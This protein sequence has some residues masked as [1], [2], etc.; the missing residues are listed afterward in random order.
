MSRSG[1]TS[2][3]H[4]EYTDYS[5]STSIERLA[6]DVETHLR[7]WHLVGTDRHVSFG[8]EH[9]ENASTLRSQYSFLSR[10][11]SSND[12]AA[13]ATAAVAAAAGSSTNNV[14]NNNNNN[15][16][17]NDTS[18]N[19]N[20]T[21]SFSADRARR[22][23][24]GDKYSGSDNDDNYQSSVPLIR[25]EK[26]EWTVTLAD[27]A[28]KESVSLV[29]SLWDGPS[30]PH[31]SS[32]ASS[33]SALPQS[34][35]R[36]PLHRMP[37]DPFA[38]FSSLLGIGQHITLSLAPS[39]TAANDGKDSDTNPSSEVEWAIARSL[40]GRHDERMLA[41]WIVTSSLSS[42][43]Q[44]S[45]QS[46][47]S[48]VSCRIPAFGLWG[49]YHPDR[50]EKRAW[51]LRTKEMYPSWLTPS[52]MVP[53]KRRSSLFHNS[54]ADQHC[55]QAYL[56]P[57]LSSNL[58]GGATFWVSVLPSR[59]TTN[60]LTVWGQLLLQHCD[61][62]NVLLCGAKHMYTWNKAAVA[63]SKQTSRVGLFSTTR[64]T[65]NLDLVDAWRIN[66]FASISGT[67]SE[68]IGGTPSNG[69]APDESD[70]EDVIASYQLE[71]CRYAVSLL[72]MASGAHTGEPMWGPPEDP[73]RVVHVTITWNGKKPSSSS[74]LPESNDAA[75]SSPSLSECSLLSM[76]LRIRS[77]KAMSKRDWM[78]MEDSV[79]RTILDPLSP[80][81]FI[82]QAQ[83][84]REI[85]MTPLAASQRC[86]LACM[87]RTATLPHNIMLPELIDTGLLHSWGST[88]TEIAAM[89]LVD[90]ARVSTLTTQLVQAMDWTTIA[91]EMMEG[92]ESTY[93]VGR[94]MN[95]LNC[96]GFPSPPA[97]LF[98]PDGVRESP[99]DCLPKSAP[100]G[101]LLSLLF[102]QMSKLR[103]PSAMAQ[104]WLTFVADVRER[105]DNRETLPNMMYIP[106]LD[107][108]PDE[109]SRMRSS[110]TISLKAD[111]SAF[112]NS[113]EP[114]PDQ[115]YCLIGQKL[116]IFN[117]GVELAI[118]HEIREA[119]RFE[120]VLH[121]TEPTSLNRSPSGGA[122]D[123]NDG[124]SVA[125]TE[126]M[127]N[128][129]SSRDV[130]N[131]EMTDSP[132]DHLAKHN[133]DD[134][135]RTPTIRDTHMP[136]GPHPHNDV[137]QQPRLV[138]SY[139]IDDVAEQAHSQSSTS[140]KVEFHDARSLLS[141]SFGPTD[142][143]D[144]EVEVD[145]MVATRDPL[146]HV[147]QRQNRHGARCPVPGVNLVASGDQL[148]AP[149]LQRPAPLS[150]DVILERR[151]MLTRQTKLESVSESIQN[152]ME[153]AHR[154][155]KPKLLS[156][157]RAFKAANP[158][159]VFQ[160]FI[161]WYGNPGSPLEE[162]G[163]KRE[164]DIVMDDLIQSV[165]NPKGGNNKNNGTTTK[166]AEILSKMS[167]AQKLD[168]ASQAIQVLNTTRDFW[169][170]T[171]DDAE[172]CAAADQEPLFDPSAQVEMVLDNLETLHPANLLNQIMAVNLS[173]SYFVLLASAGDAILVAV[174]SH[175]MERL[176]LR[177]ER[178]LDLLAR[179]AVHGTSADHYDPIQ[180]HDDPT[181]HA[182]NTDT[183]GGNNQNGK[184]FFAAK[185]R[186]PR[187]ASVEAIQAC[188]GACDALSEAETVL[189][190][191]MSLLHKFPQR[192]DLVHHILRRADSDTIPLSHPR[193]RMSILEAIRQQQQQQ[194]QQ[195]SNKNNG[196][197][198]QP[199][200]REYV[201]RNTDDAS[202]CQLCVRFGEKGAF[203][204][205]EG[206][207]MVALTKSKGADFE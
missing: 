48:N 173:M 108:T 158:G 111:N 66:S 147:T 96:L 38:N 139:P 20:S 86:M 155:Q 117:I 71:C 83:Y 145:H 195:A 80:S 109:T 119:E 85:S 99:F 125:S 23:Q 52:N 54:R 84:D 135:A 28:G 187:H 89:Y 70:V 149:Y 67:V 42:I 62:P 26:V 73:V 174:V 136:S 138:D 14:N 11:T 130:G 180:Y 194:Q 198:P 64:T 107:R 59:D 161:A 15:N 153:I 37:A 207:L 206:G 25:S 112:L 101:R 18:N 141:G 6:R 7:A 32:T 191:A 72:E 122:G 202:P 50:E 179:D 53:T 189:A 163:M 134:Q 126:L 1:S 60:R 56:P 192:Y 5:C 95:G 159:A 63:S 193:A 132:S 121:N 68:T 94:A 36:V 188:D 116:Q 55:N 157:M 146:A 19:N 105:W 47:A 124:I 118:A 154:L 175:A 98:E 46:A 39:A 205:E 92:W 74:T 35:R 165:I 177:V 144:M 97:A 160:D 133:N 77:R 113:S 76:P 8:H 142:S 17:T 143:A 75:A 186:L 30:N 171:W 31:A 164:G 128:I 69:A 81:R 129:G 43:L 3:N 45:L 78:D 90:Q 51:G 168:K 199:S 127:N 22:W 201:L 156:D 197:L 190:R 162:Y 182:D 34:L 10:S 49:H 106:G 185:E 203:D 151:S 27:G 21:T 58:M 40:V 131:N 204:D 88:D 41:P 16:A 181:E 170:N 13:A 140:S 137:S 91:N 102:F 100:P 12:I 79:E 44:T 4:D 114:D 82:I 166:S 110:S 178:A 29:L 167:V 200:M 115:S 169:S 148:Y 2:N 172:A 196:G 150:D 93:K 9:D 65:G 57:I 24:K 33:G 104:V 120:S 123:V 87:I 184:S 176:R 61:T 183:D 103:S 152:R